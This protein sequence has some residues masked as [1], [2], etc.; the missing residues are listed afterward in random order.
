LSD[1]QPRAALA[2]AA[3]YPEEI[4]AALAD[5]AS[6]TPERIWE[7]DPFTKPPAH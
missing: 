7:T 1:E 6:W 3:S 4:E 2:Y 5:N